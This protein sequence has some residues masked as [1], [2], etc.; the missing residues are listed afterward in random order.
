MA[1]LRNFMMAES[2]LTPRSK[3][4]PSIPLDPVRLAVRLLFFV[5]FGAAQLLGF[6]IGMTVRLKTVRVSST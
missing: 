6:S 5:F 4:A 1:E 2:P 3:G